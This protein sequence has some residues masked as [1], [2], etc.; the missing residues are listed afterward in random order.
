MGFIINTPITLSNGLTASGIEVSINGAY[1]VSKYK[2]LLTNESKYVV[3][4]SYMAYIN[5]LEPILSR[6]ESFLLETVAG[7]DIFVIVYARLKEKFANSEFT[8]N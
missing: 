3:H 1:Q 4:Y 8:D 6:S 7:I 5:R 2:D